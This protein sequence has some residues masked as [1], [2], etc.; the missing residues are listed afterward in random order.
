MKLE[1]TTNPASHAG[2][3][4]L[5]S[6]TAAH[7]QLEFCERL[8]LHVLGLYYCEVGVEW[9][10]QGKLE[11]DYLHHVDLAFSGHR[12][13]VFRGEVLDVEPG[14]AFWFPGNTPLERRC[15]ERCKVLFLKLRSEWLPGVDPLLDWPGRRP[16]PVGQFDAAYWRRWLAPGK[17]V[18]SNHLLQLQARLLDWIASVVPDLDTVIGEHLRTHAQ[19]NTVFSL[20]E[21]KLGANLRVEQLAKVHGTSLH[22]FSMAFARNTGL[23]PKAYLRRRLNQE[24]IQLLTNTDLKLKQVAEKLGFCDEYHFSRFFSKA[25]RISPLHYRKAFQGKAA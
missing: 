12:Q 4:T 15:G 17:Q 2:A 24:A 19:F 20:I 5:W 3:Q 25:N 13:V 10:S 23:S 1:D 16:G 11:S 9:S 14:V 7:P 8:R 22:A 6:P 21:E 18:T